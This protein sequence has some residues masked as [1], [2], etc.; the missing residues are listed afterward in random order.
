VNSSCVHLLDLNGFE[1]T[2]LILTD[3]DGVLLDWS[4]TFEQWM[5][6]RGHTKLRSD[7]YNIHDC[8]GLEYAESKKTTRMFNNSSACG[9]LEHFRD[10]KHYVRRLH[11]EHGYKFRVI[12]SFSL[13][14]WSIRLREKNLQHI[15]G[16]AIESVISLET[17]APKDD[18]LAP[19]KDSGL[20]WIDD[21]PS[22]IESGLQ[23]G[24][25]CILVNHDHN[26]DM[27]QA[28]HWRVETW[29]EIYKIITEAE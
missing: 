17:G 1:V 3:C 6:L 20:F 14:P 11:E 15:F 19:Y 26:A 21:K 29:K 7:S 16:D 23:V 2:K 13:D 22:N 18:A 28:T 27:H 8:Y 5:K 9:F 24:L 4:T 25:Q 10:A 12:T